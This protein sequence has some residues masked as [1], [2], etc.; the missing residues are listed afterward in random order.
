MNSTDQLAHLR[1][2]IDRCHI[3]E[4]IH[5]LFPLCVY[6]Y[7]VQANGVKREMQKKLLGKCVPE[8]VVF[9]Y[10]LFTAYLLLIYCLFTAYLLLIYC[11]FAVYLLFYCLFTVYLLLIYCLFTVY[12]LFIYCLFTV[13]LLFIYCFFTKSGSPEPCRTYAS[14]VHKIVFQEMR[15]TPL[16]LTAYRVW[17]QI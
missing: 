15:P 3:G 7:L 17:L 16:I 6:F 10:C 4:W 2:S 13:Y 14:P 8:R 11:L 9:I 12:L 5:Q 1:S